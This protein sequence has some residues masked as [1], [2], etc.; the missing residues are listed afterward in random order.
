MSENQ[1]DATNE[2]DQAAESAGNSLTDE[3]I[4]EWKSSHEKSQRLQADYTRK[5]QGIADQRRALEAERAV[6]EAERN[7]LQSNK[8]EA[9]PDW[10]KLNESADGLG[11]FATSI[12]QRLAKL[13]QTTGKHY[14]GNE[15]TLVAMQRD[16]AWEQALKPYAGD[17]SANLSEIKE[18]CEERKLGPENADLVYK[19]LHGDRLAREAAMK[20]NRNANAKPPMKGSSVGIQGSVAQEVA[21]PNPASVSGQSWQQIRNAARHDP[22]RPAK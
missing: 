10:F 17:S 5:T 21:R 4:A 1:L 15:A 13:E 11:D 14:S 22:R 18:Y 16:E 12:D 7:A 3:Q 6:L 8:A 9:A 19:F 2:P 20:T